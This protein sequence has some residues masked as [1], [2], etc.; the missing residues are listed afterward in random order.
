MTVQVYFRTNLGGTTTG[1]RGDPVL[2]YRLWGLLR[3]MGGTVLGGCGCLPRTRL[4]EVRGCP[5]IRLGGVQGGEAG[6]QGAAVQGSVWRG[7]HCIGISWSP[8]ISLK[9]KLLKSSRIYYR[10]FLISY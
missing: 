2:S 9:K 7:L 4:A 8:L 3:V 10:N 1:L 5:S 6:S